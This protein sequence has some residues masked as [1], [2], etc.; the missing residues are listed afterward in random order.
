MR[1]FLLAF[2]PLFV[3]VDALGLMPVFYTLTEGMDMKE[4]NKV[5]LQAAIV[6]SIVAVIFILVGRVIFRFLGIT[7]DDFMIAGGA[8]LFCISITDLIST[9]KVR[10]LSA[11]SIASVP[12]GIPLMVGP[13][14]LTTCLILVPQVGMQITIICILLNIF[15]SAIVLY[16]SHHLIGILGITGSKAFSK[17]MSLLLASIGIMLIRKG[18]EA[19]IK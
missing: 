14:V 10:K 8:I 13:A 16:Q 6:A 15:I 1:D 9:E 18:I 19:F 4:R 5:I 7:I 11:D 2:I 3:A 12:L 17:V